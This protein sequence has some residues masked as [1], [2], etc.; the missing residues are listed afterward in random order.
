MQRAAFEIADTGELQIRT[1]SNETS[2][3]CVTCT[4]LEFDPNP[5][6][7]A[8]SKQRVLTALSLQVAS[9]DGA[10][11][12]LTWLCQ[13]PKFDVKLLNVIVKDAMQSASLPLARAV[14]RKLF[15]LCHAGA[16]EKPAIDASTLSLTSG[17][18]LRTLIELYAIPEGSDESARAQLE[19][20]IGQ[21]CLWEHVAGGDGIGQLNEAGVHKITKAICCT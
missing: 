21:T 14:V 12:Q 4:A 16:G 17:D 5:H 13:Q 3:C 15:D 10:V 9:T 6:R 1:T 7:L 2:T 19:R 20:S 18:I 11:E 8:G